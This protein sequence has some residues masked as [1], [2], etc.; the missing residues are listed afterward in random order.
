MNEMSAV[1]TNM[2]GDLG[3]QK[4]QCIEEVDNIGFKA[5]LEN[6][7]FIVNLNLIH[8]LVHFEVGRISGESPIGQVDQIQRVSRNNMNGKAWVGQNID[9]IGSVN[10]G[11][12]GLMG[13]HYENHFVFTSKIKGHKGRKNKGGFSGKATEVV[14]KQKYVSAIEDSTNANDDERSETVATIRNCTRALNNWNYSNRRKLKKD[15]Q[16]KGEDL[17]PKPKIGQFTSWKPPKVG[18]WK[19]NTDAAT[20]YKD[21]LIG[22]GFIIRDGDGTVK[23]AV[24][25]K[26]TTTFLPMVAEVLAVKCGIARAVELG[27]FPFQLE[28]DSLHVV[29]LIH[30][31]ETSLTDVGPVISDIVD[32]LQ[33]IPSWS[34]NFIP[35]SGNF[36]A[37]SLAKM[38]L[39]L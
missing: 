8:T 19:I 12:Q 6:G 28:T 38:A 24:V 25:L 16:D 20:R 9:L 22:L 23:A 31:G 14:K 26:I 15:I 3:I 29:L 4:N 13:S 10:D 33:R 21:C 27:L 1:S 30:S 34:I 5:M 37:Y 2:T 11:Y 32:S 36:T 35:R 7:D 39:S 17:R 18:F